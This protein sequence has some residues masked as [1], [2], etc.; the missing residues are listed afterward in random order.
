M[1]CPECQAAGQKSTVRELGGSVTLMHCPAF[2]DEEGRRHHHDMNTRTEGF[3]CS[4]GHTWEAKSKGRCWCGWDGNAP[5]P[6]LRQG[7]D[8]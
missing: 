7:E 2:Y 3:R 8:K 1:I 5:K 6:V 4:N